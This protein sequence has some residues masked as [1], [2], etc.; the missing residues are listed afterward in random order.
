[1]PFQR[2]AAAVLLLILALLA[3]GA[4]VQSGVN[5]YDRAMFTDQIHGTAHRP[6][7]T[8]ALAPA[9]VRCICAAIPAS[10]RSRVSGFVSTNLEK[11][12]RDKWLNKGTIDATEF[13]V[14]MAVIYASIIGFALCMAALARTLYDAKPAACDAIALT[15]VAGLPCFFTWYAYVYDLPHL[16]LFTSCLVLLARRRIL[17]YLLVFLLTTISKETSILLVL[18]FILT[19][20]KPFHWRGGLPWLAAQ[21]I[22]FLVTRLCVSLYFMGTPGSFLEVHLRHNL[23]LK[24]YSFGQFIALLAVGGAIAFRWS[25]KPVFLRQAL[26]I[27][28]PLLVLTFLFG[29]LDEYR[30]YYE[31]YPVVFLLCADAVAGLV[32]PGSLPLRMPQRPLT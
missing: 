10:A 7:V 29:Y 3:L 16:F 13:I 28:G 9:V 5:G 1:M 30:D 19:W 31:V 25:Q 27:G 20:E 17:P 11:T 15:A 21:G 23:S 26:W 12:E 24:P 32:R 14:A 18:V 22:I 8:R 6:Y 4:F 2:T